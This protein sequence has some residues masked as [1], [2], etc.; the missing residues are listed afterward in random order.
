[1]KSGNNCLLGL[2]T[3]FLPSFF[4]SF[5][6]YEFCG[7]FPDFP[8]FITFPFKIKFCKGMW[9]KK[10]LVVFCTVLLLLHCTVQLIFSLLH[11]KWFFLSVLQTRWF[12]F[13]CKFLSLHDFW[14]IT[15][16]TPGKCK[17]FKTTNHL[18]MWP[19]Q[20]K[21]RLMGESAWIKIPIAL[22]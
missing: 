5:C 21:A 2:T 17:L 10:V 11:L 12:F 9:K 14:S 13:F 8:N 3:L 7:Y 20:F 15:I 4:Y 6:C 16:D 1:M 22:N 18:L 19:N